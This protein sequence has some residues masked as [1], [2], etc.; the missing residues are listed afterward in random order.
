[1]LFA[2][3]RPKVLLLAEWQP[4]ESSGSDEDT[5]MNQGADNGTVEQLY[6]ALGDVVVG[7]Y[8][9]VRER[10]KGEPRTEANDAIRFR[11]M[12]IIR[13]CI[14]SIPYSWPKNTAELR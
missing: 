1:M 2:T 8:C 13:P 3:H 5:L 7:H 6:L 12:F 14:H 9:G 10:H 4:N 11:G